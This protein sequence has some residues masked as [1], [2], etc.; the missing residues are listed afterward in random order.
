MKHVPEGV[1]KQDVH[2][3][4]KP[5][6]DEAD[7]SGDG[8]VDMD[9][10]RAAMKAHGPKGLAAKD[11]KKK[12][13]A[14]ELAKEGPTPADVIDACDK[15]GSGGIS[16]KEAHA[17]IDEYISDPE[18]NAMAHK[19][20]K[21]HFGDVDRDNSGEVDEHELSAAMKAHEGLAQIQKGGKGPSP[22]DIIEACDADGS[23]GISKDE[24]HACIDAHISDPSD[25]EM[26]HEAVDEGFDYVDKDGSGEV[27]EHELSAA[28][29]A[30]KK[31]GKKPKK[32]LAQQGP[33]S[34]KD[35]KAMVD[36]CDQADA[37]G[38]FDGELSIDEVC[39]CFNAP[40]SDVEPI[41]SMVD[42]DGSGTVSVKE[43]HDFIKSHY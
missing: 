15:N 25:N 32:E 27:D 16:R 8:L 21:K 20:V 9:E 30:H 12:K 13:A 36:H 5:L 29:K 37:D 31:G 4:M 43:I 1:T 2:D 39:A 3:H 35:I 6:F 34:K 18:E 26:A 24:A 41:F 38:S 42:K 19:M 33:P 22:A 7:T 28:M 11:K 40:R 14:K 17:C 10:L 23:G